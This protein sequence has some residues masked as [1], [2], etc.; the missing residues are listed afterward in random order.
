MIAHHRSL[1]A[2]PAGLLVCRRLLTVFSL[3]ML[4]ALAFVQAAEPRLLPQYHS[5]PGGPVQPGTSFAGVASTDPEGNPFD[6]PATVTFSY[7]NGV[8]QILVEGSH[9]DSAVGNYIDLSGQGPGIIVVIKTVVP[10]FTG[11]YSSYTNVEAYLV[12]I[13]DF[14]DGGINVWSSTLGYNI[15][16]VDSAGQPWVPSPIKTYSH[17]TIWSDTLLIFSG[18]GT[19]LTFSGGSLY[20]DGTVIETYDGP[21]STPQSP[22]QLRVARWQGATPSNKGA[23]TV[24]ESYLPDGWWV[25]SGVLD[26]ANW[27]TDTGSMTW[28]NNGGSTV[29]FYK[30]YPY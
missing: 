11:F 15:T 22:Q 9:W 20:A 30:N 23:I 2:D 3:L 28:S 21:A 19:A 4:N 6:I 8:G 26:L 10:D 24:I 18:S 25:G 17:P 1:T 27:D 12:K 7:T 16:S 14:L 5:S 13:K 29:T